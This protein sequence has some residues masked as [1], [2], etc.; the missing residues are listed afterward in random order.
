MSAHSPIGAADAPAAGG[1]QWSRPAHATAMDDHRSG[2]AGPGPRPGGHRA[3][4]PA[5]GGLPAPLASLLGRLPPYPG[6]LLFA[7]GLNLALRPHLP[8]DVRASLEGR[9]LRIAVTDAGVAFDFAWRQG[10]GARQG[11]FHALPRGSQ[12]D[13]QIAASAR[14][15]VALARR[16]EDPD[17]LFFSR[18]LAM[19]G[20]TELGLLVK[21]TLDAMETP[22][23][24]ALRAAL[25][26][27]L[28]RV[29]PG[30]R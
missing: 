20:D 3:A 26:D 30:P 29:R 18:R 27:W 17:T 15:F 10:R 12:P 24:Q 22:L 13:L 6:S 23:P 1:A 8:D 7:A 25:A 14:D 4:S 11:H 5:L 16:E 9:S 21:N 19:S 28:N 2:G